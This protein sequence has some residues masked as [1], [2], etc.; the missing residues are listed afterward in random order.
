VEL[1]G[2]IQ[3][4]K[5][6]FDILYFHPSLRVREFMMSFLNALSSEFLGRSYLLQKKDIV[7]VLVSSLYGEG[8]QDTY[9]R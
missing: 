4:D 8:K 1:T 3:L 7:K 9:L 5:T 2:G 6:V